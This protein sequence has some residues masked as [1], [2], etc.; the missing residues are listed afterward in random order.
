MPY[1]LTKMLC[2][3]R[4]F[5]EL[6]YNWFISLKIKQQFIPYSRLFSLGTN[7]PEWTHNL[8]KFILRCCS[9]KVRLW[10]VGGTWRDRNIS[11]TCC[12]QCRTLLSSKT[13][14]L[15]LQLLMLKFQLATVGV[16]NGYSIQPQVYRCIA[17]TSSYS[18]LYSVQSL[19]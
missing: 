15:Q 3:H 12:I 7:F 16:M 2:L 4:N 14:S 18:Q 10:V 17:T 5:Y 6:I 13:L 9:Y 11:L 19:R 1:P 8:G